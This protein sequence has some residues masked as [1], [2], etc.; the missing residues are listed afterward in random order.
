MFGI[1]RSENE[2]GN[3]P[4]NQ[5]RKYILRGN[6]IRAVSFSR[7]LRIILAAFLLEIISGIGKGLFFV[8][9]LWTKP[10]QITDTLM[11]LAA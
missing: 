11:P 4:N 5:A 6:A 8:I 10:G 3:T 2:G 9:P 1:S 7:P